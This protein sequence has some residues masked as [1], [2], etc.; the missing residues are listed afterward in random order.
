MF[1]EFA[2]MP[3]VSRM[4][5]SFFATTPGRTAGRLFPAVNVWEDEQALYIEAELPGYALEDLDI[6]TL[7]NEVT[8]AGTR[9]ETAPEEATFHRRE[10]MTSGASQFKRTLRIGVPIEVEKVLAKLEQGVLT[11]TLPKAEAAK[12]RRIQV[13]AA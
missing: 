7:G 4:M 11:I 10:R 12:P 13:K 1:N 2:A 9:T 8:I 6:S 3:D 5:D